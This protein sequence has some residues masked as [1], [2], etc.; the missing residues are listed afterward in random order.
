MSKA[1]RITATALTDQDILTFRATLGDRRDVETMLMREAC[2]Q[3]MSGA[4]GLGLTKRMQLHARHKV[5]QA[6]E[7]IPKRAS[8]ALPEAQL[9]CAG[10]S[11]SHPLGSLQAP[12]GVTGCECWCNR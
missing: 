7:A 2:S 8:T 10:C 1:K 11:P 9:A 12:C 3:S 6:I 5:A 4:G